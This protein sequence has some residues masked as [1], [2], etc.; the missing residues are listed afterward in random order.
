MKLKPGYGTKTLRENYAGLMRAGWTSR[1]AHDRAH[2][3]ARSE[4]WKKYPHGFL[5]VWIK[6]DPET[7]LRVNPARGEES[8]V[9]MRSNPARRDYSEVKAAERLHRAFVGRDAQERE[10][11]NFPKV[12]SALVAFADVAAIE[13]IAERDGKVFRFRHPFKQKSRPLMCVSPD[14]KTVYMYGGAWTFTED[15]FVDED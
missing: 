15:G 9:N 8:G 12:P 10:T 1:Q 5:P 6:P 2:A 14:G 7:G 13:Y 11:I 4:Y 3:H